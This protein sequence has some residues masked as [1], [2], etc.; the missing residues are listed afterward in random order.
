ML[1]L[2]EKLNNYNGYNKDIINKI[3]K[4]DYYTYY[5]I[6]EDVFIVVGYV[7]S[8]RREYRINLREFKFKDTERHNIKLLESYH[9]DDEGEFLDVFGHKYSKQKWTYNQWKYSR[10]SYI[11]SHENAT[12]FTS[13]K[14]DMK[15][16]HKIFKKDI[17]IEN[18]GKPTIGFFDIETF[19]ADGSFPAPEKDMKH[20]VTAI[21]ISN[22]RT[23]RTHVF[24]YK[25]FKVNYETKYKIVKHVCKDEKDLLLRFLRHLKKDKYDVF[26][27][28][29]VIGYDIPFLYWRIDA[30]LN[31]GQR[32]IMEDF[33]DDGNKIIKTVKEDKVE[34]KAE[35][36]EWGC[37]DDIPVETATKKEKDYC[38][39][40]SYLGNVF[41][42]E[43][44][45]ADQE[46]KFYIRGTSVLDYM[47]LYKKLAFVNLQN[48]RLNT[49][50]EYE[51][52]DSKLNYQDVGTI[53][54]LYFN[55]FDLYVQYNI[56]DVE[57]LI[58]LDA[59]LDFITLVQLQAYKGYINIDTAS[60][61]NSKVN[62][63][64]I[65][66]RLKKKDRLYPDPYDRHKESYPGAFVQ[67]NP[68]FYDFAVS[69][70]FESLY[71]AIIRAFNLS[72]EMVVDK[73][74]PS[75]HRIDNPS[76]LCA[77]KDKGLG[78]IAE[79]VEEEFM[80][81]RVYKKLKS[82]AKAAGDK[83]K[84]DMYENFQMSQKIVINSTYGC[85]G[86]YR[87]YFYDLAIANAITAVARELI[88]VVRDVID[89]EHL[90]TTR[91]DEI[92]NDLFV[93]EDIENNIKEF[94]VGS[95]D[96][97]IKRNSEYYETII[98]NVIPTDDIL[99][100]K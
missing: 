5:G 47:D 96:V 17:D 69:F 34:E 25:E 54:T 60:T 1:S 21:T 71:P 67:A 12:A 7:K 2:T 70:D 16:F 91:V 78:I 93:L 61:S 92:Y 51:L 37:Y 28:W 29:N 88:K 40:L 30:V 65:F 86:D 85:L 55:D 39:D 82:E 63:G 13:V 84:V 43:A 98:R 59:K 6:V 23:K 46:D 72:P 33:D 4:L 100:E 38:Q 90:N 66:K 15:M 80:L 9:R 74:Y 35:V 73:D 56:K 24:T 68:G 75:E 26:T 87:F 36:D 77:S 3:N 44:K 83:D 49:V 52:G 11:N 19:T 58:D 79:Y 50:A 22:N 45:N 10:R 97:I 53:F 95:D 14:A 48:Y 99:I 41:F 81:R 64:A 42:M 32:N 31:K 27:G 76:G 89:D 62:E 8:M 20:P 94:F 18:I 57:L